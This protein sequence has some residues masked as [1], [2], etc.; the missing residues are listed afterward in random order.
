L[1]SSKLIK[2]LK[3][4]PKI[5]INEGLKMTFDWYLKNQEYYSSLKKRDITVRLGNKLK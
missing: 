3:W 5:N 1:N 2:D 4:K